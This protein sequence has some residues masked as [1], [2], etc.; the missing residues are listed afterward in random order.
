MVTSAD[1]SATD[2]SGDRRATGWRLCTVQQV[3]DLKSLLAT[4]PIWSCGILLSLSVG[5]LL[6]MAVLQAL[7]MDRSLGPRFK[8]PAGSITVGSLAAFIVV[9]LFVD[10]VVFPL[11]RRATGAIPTPL[12]RVGLGHVLNVA[13][14]V[15]AALVER[16]R[17]RI[18]RGH[19]GAGS[20]ALGWVTPMSVMWLVFPL[21]LAGAGEAVH[22]PGNMAFFY[23][24]Y[25]AR[26]RSLATAMAPLLS[27]LG[28]F[29]TTPFLDMVKRDTSWLPVNIN[30]G[31][32]D[33]VYWTLAAVAAANFGYLLIC[34]SLYKGRKPDE[35]K[36]IHG[37][38]TGGTL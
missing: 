5:V 4:L 6:F 30:E 1:S 20:E 24:E 7:A 16:R 11:W 31:R 25:P 38:A 8:V 12:Q 32:L 22:F 34:I 18:V 21:G 10:R 37:T 17:L 26:L 35:G 9:A 3:E 29:L 36:S 14:M 23:L 13:A 19:H 2:V 33:N 27:G 28:F 15:S